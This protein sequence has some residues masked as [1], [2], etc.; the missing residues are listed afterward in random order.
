M[1]KTFDNLKTAFSGESQ[2]NR[3]YLAYAQQAEKEG[4]PQVARLFRA[5]AEAETVHALS[6]LKAMGE[7]K[8][9]RE[10]LLAAI[11]GEN[12]EFQQMYPDMIAT[13]ATEGENPAHQSFHY[14]NQVEAIHAALFQEALETLGELDR[15]E[16]FVCPVCG[17]TVEKEAPAACA[18]CQTPRKFF[19]RID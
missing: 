2:A 8:S 9:T 1:S 15:T 4:F 7:V 18:I 14:A 13:A 17:N 12:Y 5:A 3:K 6:H 10:N 19:R 11:A 16:L